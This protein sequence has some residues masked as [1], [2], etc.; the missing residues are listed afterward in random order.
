M[1]RNN[2]KSVPPNERS[3]TPVQLHGVLVR[4][5]GTGVLLI[6]ESGIG[7]SECALDLVAKGHSLVA[8]DIVNAAKG[9]GDRLVGSAPELTFGLLEIRGLGVIDVRQ[10]FGYDAVCDS[11]TIDLC[12]ELRFDADVERIGDVLAEHDIADRTVPKFLLPV[13]PGRNLA[14]IVETAARIYSSRGTAHDAGRSLIEKQ[15]ALI[16]SARLV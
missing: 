16:A 1:Q 15:R 14:T 4:V 9:E 12:V 10:A 13:T 6:G 7:K 11:H 5:L 8:D 3:L 2:S